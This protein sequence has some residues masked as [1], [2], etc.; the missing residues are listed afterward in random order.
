M[1]AGSVVII[2]RL[3]AAIEMSMR[4]VSAV[5][6]PESMPARERLALLLERDRYIETLTSDELRLFKIWAAQTEPG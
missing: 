1:H 4:C 6:R 5:A 2:S 3:S